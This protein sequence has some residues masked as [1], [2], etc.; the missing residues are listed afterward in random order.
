MQ[1]IELRFQIPPEQR[2]PLLLWLKSA[3]SLRSERLQ[4]AYFDTPARDLA[5][6]GFALRLR[7]EG[8]RWVQTL[9]GEA[10]D[11][12][13][14]PEHNV[15]LG[16]SAAMPALDVARHA[17]HPA[18]DV[19]LARVSEL[20]GEAA[21]HCLFR[22]DIRRHSVL[23]TQGDSV[24]ELALDEGRLVADAEAGQR[25]IPVL[26]LEIELKSG[27]PGALLQLARDFVSTHGLWLEH[28]SKA[29][30]GD[31]LARAQPA[32]PPALASAAPWRRGSSAQQALKQLLQAALE[33]L[34]GNASQIASGSHAPEHL[35]QLR[36]GLLRLMVG[37]QLLQG[38]PAKDGGPQ[39]QEL[40]AL[41]AAA[42][43]LRRSLS[44]ARD[45]D[46]QSQTPWQALLDA[47]WRATGLSDD[48]AADTADT[49]DG[50]PRRRAAELLRSVE[51][52][53]LMLDLLALLSGAGGSRTDS[54]P[55]PGS[56]GA[57]RRSCQARLARWQDALQGS[58]K[59]ITG[60]AAEERHR[61]RQRL[62]RLRYAL[63][64]T[65]ELLPGAQADAQA[66]GLKPLHQQLGELNDLE[67]A[68]QQARQQA[69]Q[70]RRLQA[71][72]ALGYLQP[73]HAL[74]LQQADASWRRW[75]KR[76]RR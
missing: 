5:A 76:S 64:Q 58:G 11:G 75:R 17:G 34:L 60:L 62:R 16:Q 2:R 48:D 67:Q 15:A 42:Q 70:Q 47:A 37:L 30:R 31:L 45:A 36:V 51:A 46:V 24:L 74:R 25:E 43:A 1:E 23:L 59:H 69:A 21:L 44:A 54:V 22:T 50:G 38:L 6:A 53:A 13:T 28:R 35:H 65:A 52:Q 19:L 66:Q 61:L 18:G 71:A 72:F 8:R 68:L 29:L 26:E 20:G 73:E 12:M 14:R 7:R 55:H 57:L 40:R 33:P 10:S 39:E 56:G 49:A 32:A 41:R 27:S 9:K 3:G 63:E 4:A